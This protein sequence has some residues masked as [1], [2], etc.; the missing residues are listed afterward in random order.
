MKLRTVD[1]IRFSGD[2]HGMN[3]LRE[4]MPYA[5]VRCPKDLESTA[6]HRLEGDLLYT[7]ICVTNPLSKPYIT[8]MDDISIA[9]PLDTRYNETELCLTSRAHVHLFCGGNV[10]WAMAM[11]MGGDAPHLGMVLTQGSLAGYSVEHNGPLAHD[12]GKLLL[13]PASVMWQPGETKVWAWTIFPHQG[14]E[15]F[16]RQLPIFSRYVHVEANPYVLYPGE[17]GVLTVRPAF[18]AQ[19]VTVDGQTLEKQNGAYVLR[20]TAQKLGEHTFQVNVDGIH[21]WCRVLIHPNPDALA[22][23]RVQFI[24][25]HQQY[26]GDIAALNGA[27]LAYDNEEEHVVYTPINDYNGGRERVAMGILMARYLSNGGLDTDDSLRGSL[28][29][30]RSYVLRELV[31]AISGQV[32]NDI[33]RDVSYMRTYNYP[34]FATFFLEYHQLAGHTEDLMLAWRIA[35]RFYE[36]ENGVEFYP[37]ELPIV[38]LDAALTGANLLQE[39]EALRTWEIRHAEQIL[40]TGVHYPPFEVAF[41]Q[42]IIGPAADV[43]LQVYQLTGDERY[44]HGAEVHLRL[45]EL[46]NGHQPDYH[47]YEVALRNWDGYWFGKRKLFGDTFPHYWSGITANVFQRYADLT[48]NTDY[49][50]R[51]ENSRRGILPMIFPDGRASCAYIYPMFSNGTQGGFYDPYANDQD[52]G[53]YFSLRELES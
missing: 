44:L 48:G 27:Y 11:R 51:A 30:Y 49:A 8:K 36:Q 24:R 40:E 38:Q 16:F 17:E 4:D 31:D 47:C 52:W 53:L 26:H 45:L 20:W 21:T 28:E 43:L 34:W 7:E 19:Q 25:D 42:S 10:S 1:A 14:E 50:R 6:T 2:P 5:Q 33:G 23:T 46:L 12:R 37:I 9:M 41:E 29:A 32:F 22:R 3:W 18:E 15:D 13:H 39:R 35:M